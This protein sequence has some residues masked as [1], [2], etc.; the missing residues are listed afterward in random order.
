MTSEDDF[1]AKLDETP[2]D[3]QTRM[4][5]ADYL[6]DL[7]DPRA[8]G[9]RLMGVR[10]R[11]PVM[12]FRDRPSEETRGV[13]YLRTSRK[14][15]AWMDPHDMTAKRLAFWQPTWCH[16][17]LPFPWAAVM[18]SCTFLDRFVGNCTLSTWN[19]GI[20]VF[21]GRR[22]AEDCAAFA[23]SLL[24]PAYRTLLYDTKIDLWSDVLCSDQGV[25]K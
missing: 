21:T 1:Q 10:C 23:V 14:G 12:C 7:D 24:S 5:F 3:W 2:Y 18:E 9:Y 17:W 4:V 19:P 16:V 15:W 6:G 11:T 8:E 13:V 22:L 20:N 25:A